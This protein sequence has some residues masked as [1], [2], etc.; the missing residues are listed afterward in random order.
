MATQALKR[1]DDA[2]LSDNN[3]LVETLWQ[4]V[5]HG[6]GSLDAVPGLVRR[7]IE[8]GA[9]RRRA[10][11]GRV[12]EH[13]RFIDFITAKPLAGCGWKPERVEALIH[14]D[15]ETLTLWREA[16]TAPVGKP[17]HNNDNIIIKPEQGTSRAYALERLKRESPTLYRRVVAGELSANA[18]AIEAGF[19][20]KPTPFEQVRKLIPKLSVRERRSL[21]EMLEDS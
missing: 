6:A 21:R 4:A 19:R 16:V 1:P 3:V 18:A 20:K 8:T 17:G 5:D 13:K 7:V 15:A 9:W 2:A 12:F 10:C 14:H 11:R